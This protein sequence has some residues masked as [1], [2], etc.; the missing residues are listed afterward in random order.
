MK[1]LWIVNIVFPEAQA[2]LTGHGVLSSSGG[3]LIGSSRALSSR[4][5]IEL[6][7]AAPSAAVKDL[8]E[9]KGER[10]RYFLFPLGKGNHKKNNEYRK[11]WRI[12]N[13]KL[14][15]DVVHIHGTEFSHGLAFVDEC[16]AD[17]VI[18]SIQGLTSEIAKYYYL[19]LSKRQ[20]IQYLSFGDIFRGSVIRDA[21]K[22]K[23]RG[24]LEKE[25]L[26]RVNHVI[27]RTG[28]DKSHVWGI[29]PKINYHF[30]NEV[31]REEFYEGRWKYSSCNP[32]TIFLSQGN[33]PVK[34]LHFMIEALRIVKSHY[35]S[36]KMY[37]A[38]NDITTCDFT[39]RG[40]YAYSGYG[41]YIKHLIKKYG[42][43]NNVIFTGPYAAH[44]MKSA[45]L[46]ANVFVCSSTIENS[47]NSLSEAQILGVPCIAAYV[48]GIPDMIPN[49]QCGLLYRCDDVVALAFHICRVFETSPMFDNTAMIETALQ[50][51]DVSVN[52]EQ[53]LSIYN[54]LSK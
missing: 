48:G 30:C 49:E 2:L 1:V 37:V 20:I 46:D 29:N 26:K 43:R 10:I 18:V 8:T 35:P 6:S 24:Q 31:L 23:Q 40:V 5:C 12:I 21:Y 17:N 44:Q 22:Y 14:K 41:K 13:K 4:E 54:S 39:L 52:S 53:L 34:G 45:L 51:H 28:F 7:V 27:G 32:Q 11:T 3:W 33:Y 19:G 36:A 42:L 16:G 25:L 38:G 50:R 47:P 15:P 9:L